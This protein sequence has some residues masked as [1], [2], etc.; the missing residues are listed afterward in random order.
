[1]DI[2]YRAEVDI[3]EVKST[4]TTVTNNQLMLEIKG[5]TLSGQAVFTPEE[6]IDWADSLTS[7]AMA[8][9]KTDAWGG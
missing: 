6:L 7:F 8:G 4:L 1:M 2:R 9:K 3:G 5:G